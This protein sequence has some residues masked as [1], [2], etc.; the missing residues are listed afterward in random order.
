MPST[1]VRSSHAMTPLHIGQHSD[2]NSRN[3][4]ANRPCTDSHRLR[5]CGV[6]ALDVDNSPRHRLAP[7]RVARRSCNASCTS[8]SP[9]LHSIA[10][11]AC[12]L[13]AR[14]RSRSCLLSFRG[15][16]PEPRTPCPIAHIRSLRHIPRSPRHI[17]ASSS[18]PATAPAHPST[19][20]R[21]PAARISRGIFSRASR[22]DH[23][24]RE[25]SPCCH[26]SRALA[27]IK[28]PRRQFDSSVRAN[29][30]DRRPSARRCTR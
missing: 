29:P 9:A 30:P 10:D 24:L 7:R 2:K 23:F 15:R 6:V 12:E 26:D 25:L 27:Q 3:R 19:R 22:R 1:P 18:P 17:H 21:R 13:Q 4:P 8:G 11:A 28:H 16:R 5:S 14:R 20:D